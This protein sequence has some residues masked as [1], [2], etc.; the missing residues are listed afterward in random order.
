MK[1]NV[2]SLAVLSVY[3]FL[4]VILYLAYKCYKYHMA[5]KVRNRLSWWLTEDSLEL[6]DY[7]QVK[8]IG[9]MVEPQYLITSETDRKVAIEIIDAFREKTKLVYIKE[10]YTVIRKFSNMS[11]PEYFMYRLEAF[12]SEYNDYYFNGN[13]MYIETSTKYY[14]D[15]HLSYA[16]KCQITEYGMVFKKLQYMSLLF[17]ENSVYLNANF[18][19]YSEGTKKAINSKEAIFSRYS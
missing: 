1:V 5:E 3:F 12:L 16:V 19:Y 4:C 10:Q 2:L 18:D 11:Y 17:C 6:L 8:C 9:E 13:R 15:N 14:D 7:I